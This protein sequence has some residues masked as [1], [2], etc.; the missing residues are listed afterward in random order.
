MPWLKLLVCFT[1]AIALVATA[2]LAVDAGAPKQAV[3]ASMDLSKAFGTRSPWQFTATQGPAISDPI[4]GS[5]TGDRVP[6]DILVCLHRQGGPCDTGL[7]ATLH[8]SSPDDL[9]ATPH[10]LGAAQIVHPRGAE[11]RALFLIR[12]ASILSGDGD[13]VVRTQ[14]LAYRRASDRFVRVYDFT[15]GRNNNQE[16]R[17]I[18]SGR[19]KGDIVSA[20]PTE[21]APYGFWVTVNALA[22]DYSYRPILKYRSTTRYGDGNTLAV[23]DSEMPNIEQRLGLWR[24]GAPLPLPASPCP[25]PH[26]SRMELW[27]K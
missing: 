3:I 7:Q 4:T 17:Y 21:N 24:P 19:L 8:A 9:F 20:V 2:M 23:I 6:G 11:G 13:Q 10:Y 12:M 5:F 1:L 18:A 22:P 26:L 25:K 14:V 15:T 16:V 27:C